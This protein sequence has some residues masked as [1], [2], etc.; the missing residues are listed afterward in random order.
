MEILSTLWHR[1]AVG[2]I[3][4]LM[5]FSHGTP[6]PL[7]SVANGNGTPTMTA[8]AATPP[9][10]NEAAAKPSAPTA[11]DTQA[12]QQVVDPSIKIEEC[13]TAE[14]Y[15]LAAYISTEEAKFAQQMAAIDQTLMNKYAA[16][17]ASSL[18]SAYTAGQGSGITSINTQMEA[19]NSA[20]QNA[21]SEMQTFTQ[22]KQ[23]EYANDYTILSAQYQQ[24]TD[25]YSQYLKT[26]YLECL[27]N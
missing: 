23:D 19:E 25:N 20:L 27:S 15:A 14:E 5:L 26:Q 10:D 17:S 4:V 11:I 6:T 1:I 16:Y 3:A 22:M 9:K 13:K 8:T 21:N 12:T 2:A 18:Q 7:Q 24:A